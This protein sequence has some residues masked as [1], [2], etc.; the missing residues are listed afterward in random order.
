MKPSVPPLLKIAVDHRN[1]FLAAEVNVGGFPA[2]EIQETMFVALLR[3]VVNWNPVAVW[4]KTAPNPRTL[5]KNKWIAATDRLVD[6][7]LIKDRIG[8][9]STLCPNTGRW[10]RISNLEEGQVDL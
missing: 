8:T 6:Y 3:Q 2:H 4:G 9:V 10:H 1:Y 5:H 7:G